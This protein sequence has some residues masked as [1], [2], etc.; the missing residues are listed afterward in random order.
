MVARHSVRRRLFA[1]SG[2]TIL[3]MTVFSGF[4]AGESG[5]S[6][7]STPIGVDAIK[8]TLTGHRQWT[9]YWD[10]RDLRRPRI[11]GRTADRSPTATL[12]FM[13]LG[14]RFVAHSENDEVLHVECEF[15]VTVKEDGFIFAG[16]PPGSDKTMTYDPDDPECPFKGRTNGTLLWLAPSR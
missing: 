1:F 4:T 16:C 9:L 12:E 13:R 14:Q 11:G 2:V 10:R 5:K 15:E 8:R 6:S 7:I 3:S